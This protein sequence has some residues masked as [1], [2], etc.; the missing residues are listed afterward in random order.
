MN[1][2]YKSLAALAL[3]SLALTGCATPQPQPTE[4]PEAH[5]ILRDNELCF[6]NDSNLAV[7]ITWQ[8]KIDGF[9]GQGELAPGKKFCG[10]GVGASA[11][12]KFFSGFTTFVESQ[13]VPL[14]EPHLLFESEDRKTVYASAYYS[15]NETVNSN[16]EGRQFSA[17]RLEDDEWINFEIHIRG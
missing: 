7:T 2:V 5:G 6:I 9:D 15:V 10:Q 13:N 14:L 4:T 11:Y 3:A 16:V 1:T 17:T 8:D 12:V